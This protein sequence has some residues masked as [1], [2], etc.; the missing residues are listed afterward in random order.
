MINKLQDILI[1]GDALD[2]KIDFNLLVTN[3]F[4]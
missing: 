3:E 4:N 1:Y 2:D